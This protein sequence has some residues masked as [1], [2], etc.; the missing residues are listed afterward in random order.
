MGE[1][2]RSFSSPAL[3]LSHS[4]Q[5]LPAKPIQLRLVDAFPSFVYS[6]QGLSQHAQPFLC[7]SHFPIRLG[8]QSKII[9][10]EKPY[11]KELRGLP[12]LLT[13]LSGPA[14]DALDFWR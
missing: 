9:R 14:I 7:L 11:P 12:E 4:E 8:Q 5:Q 10:P 1:W 13:Q 6:I 2:G 3:P